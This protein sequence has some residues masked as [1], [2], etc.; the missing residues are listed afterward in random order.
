MTRW[1][2]DSV[3]TIREAKAGSWPLRYVNDFLNRPLRALLG[4]FTFK[5][6]CSALA[7]QRLL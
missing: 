1:K 6:I 5:V 4:P 3:E 2:G 7:C